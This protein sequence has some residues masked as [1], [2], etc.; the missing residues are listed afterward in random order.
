MQLRVYSHK[1]SAPQ[2]EVAKQLQDSSLYPC[3]YNYFGNPSFTF[4]SLLFCL[5]EICPFAS[6]FP[7]LL[8]LLV[9]QALLT[10]APICSWLWD[11]G[12]GH[13]GW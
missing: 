1:P 4:F 11:V 6:L 13:A 8:S 5:R 3:E 2:I 10:Y 7:A 12:R 9:Q